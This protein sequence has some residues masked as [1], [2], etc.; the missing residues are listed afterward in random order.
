MGQ[1]M[2]NLP[3]KYVDEYRDRNGKWRRYFRRRG[4]RL[5]VLPGEVGS[6]EFMT[7]YAAFLAEK[8]QLAKTPLVA[9][10]LSRLIVDF[11]GDRMFLDRKPST[12]QLYRYALE[13][14]TKAH[15][16]RSYLLLTADKAEKI[17]ADIGAKR[18]GM[19]NLTRAV[20]RRV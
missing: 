15:G 7:A 6:E 14:I 4:K 5:G 2:A 20:L 13:P 16:H 11:Y 1:T 17:I 3:L 12:R 8:P 19:A 18:P 9:D 10:S